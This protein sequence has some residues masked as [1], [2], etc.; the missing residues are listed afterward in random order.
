MGPVLWK[1]HGM[2]GPP[3]HPCA[4]GPRQMRKPLL[5]RGWAAW[6]LVT[7]GRCPAIVGHASS[8][9]GVAAFMPPCCM[10]SIHASSNFPPGRAAA[11][12]PTTAMRALIRTV[13]SRRGAPSVRDGSILQGRQNLAP[14]PTHSGAGLSICCCNT[15]CNR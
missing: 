1:H 14:A 2:S 3:A 5:Q 15:M 8:L 11:G 9:S 6:Q 10:I 4:G 7:G 13:V 12:A